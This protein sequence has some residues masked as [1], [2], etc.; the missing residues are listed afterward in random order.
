MPRRK[1]EHA[2]EMR[3]R[4]LAG[5][6]RAILGA[7]YRGA[8]VDDIAAEAGVSVGLLYRYFGSKEAL[9][10]SVCRGITDQAL[11]ALAGSLREIDD[12][13]ERLRLAINAFIESLDQNSWGKLIANAWLEADSSDELRAL[14]LGR[15]DQLRLFAADFLRDAIARGDARSDIDVEALSLATAVLLEGIVA[16]RAATGPTF[17]AEATSGAVSRLLDGAFTASGGVPHGRKSSA[18]SFAAK[19]R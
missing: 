12:P 14:V 19:R 10:L 3:A 2:D 5:A 13:Q 11:D 7:G 6:E 4:I 18:S 16:R 9:F 15:F 8:T 1:P 17:D